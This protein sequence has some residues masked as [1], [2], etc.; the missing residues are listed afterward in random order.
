MAATQGQPVA[1]QPVGKRA[2]HR[3]HCPYDGAELLP[4]DLREAFT[5]RAIEQNCAIEI[6]EAGEYLDQ[7]EGVTCLQ[8]VVFTV[9]IDEVG[10]T[11]LR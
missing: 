5:A 8:R 9:E 2:G 10:L 4:V 3:Q 7:H 6:V 11:V 1:P